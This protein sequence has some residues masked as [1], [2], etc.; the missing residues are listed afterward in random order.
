MRRGSAASRRQCGRS[1]AA[2]RRK[3]FCW[4]P[5]RLT[6]S[7]PEGRDLHG[8]TE[9][10]FALPAGIKRHDVGELPGVGKV[11]NDAVRLLV[12]ATLA[13]VVLQ[14][15]ARLEDLVD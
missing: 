6:R 7:K 11:L 3:I 5:A 15:N 8:E 12:E 2:S 1:S 4:L 9:I 14:A 13:C 10:A